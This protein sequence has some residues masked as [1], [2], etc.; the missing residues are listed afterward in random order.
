MCCEITPI[1]ITH[2]PYW[3]TTTVLFKRKAIRR[4]RCLKFVDIKTAWLSAFSTV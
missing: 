4:D 2:V 1:L 3:T